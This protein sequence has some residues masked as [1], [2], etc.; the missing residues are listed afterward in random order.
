MSAGHGERLSRDQ[1]K[2]IAALLISP[3]VASAATVVGC[4]PNTIR[5]WQRQPAFAEA[6]QAARSELLG[7]TVAKLQDSLFAVVDA[8]T[9]DL[10]DADPAVRHKAAE[11]LLV[12]SLRASEI[13][14][15]AGRF[16]DLERLV[17]GGSSGN[18]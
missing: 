8:L 14:R 17:K 7:R 12:H 2:A 10:A 4:H 16:D 9:R 1:E 3:N 6:Y 11:L 13:E 15:L 5:N 18:A